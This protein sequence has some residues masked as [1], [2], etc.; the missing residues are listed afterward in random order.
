MIMEIRNNNLII[1]IYSCKM[2]T[3]NKGEKVSDDCN[4]KNDHSNTA[5]TQFNLFDT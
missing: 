3:C 5:V 2:G 4:D 1:A